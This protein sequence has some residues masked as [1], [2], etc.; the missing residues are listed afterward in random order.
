MEKSLPTVLV[1]DDDPRIR[2][3]LTLLLRFSK[4]EVV[5]AASPA[6]ALAAVEA[7]SDIGLVLADIV[8]PQMNGYDLADEIMQIRP[9]VRMVFMSGVSADPMRRPVNA[10]C[11][12]KP[13]TVEELLRVVDE[14]LKETP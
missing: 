3:L 4:F 5:A 14:A 1:V 2:D 9:G 13:F 7:R 10:P 12:A 6:E 8:M 11:L